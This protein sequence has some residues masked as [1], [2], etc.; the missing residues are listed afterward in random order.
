ML[1]QEVEGNSMYSNYDD[2]F[3]MSTTM[4]NLSAEDDDLQ[5]RPSDKSKMWKYILMIIAFLVL[6][7]I[8]YHV[9]RSRKNSYSTSL[10]SEFKSYS[11]SLC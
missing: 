9:V 5:E 6:A 7:Y 2:A 1:G 3:D 10:T 8:I 4:P 11:K